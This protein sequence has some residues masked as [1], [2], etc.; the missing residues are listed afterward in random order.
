MLQWAQSDPVSR[1]PTTVRVW[2]LQVWL[3]PCKRDEIPERQ[4]YDAPVY[5]TSERRG[6]LS[7]TGH[8][9]N[10]VMMMTVPSDR[11]QAHWIC[12]GV[13][14]CVCVCVCACV[15]VCAGVL[16]TSSLCS[17]NFCRGEVCM[18][19]CTKMSNS[20]FVRSRHA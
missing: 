6:V 17:Q 10:F 19:G 7:T 16:P 13:C 11:P 5:K 8:S 18:C 9:T 2:C 14:V 15:R 1:F 12:R 3:K 20:M 4:V